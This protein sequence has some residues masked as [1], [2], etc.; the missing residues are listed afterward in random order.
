MKKLLVLIA[1]ITLTIV[2]T[3]AQLYLTG[4]TWQMTSFGEPKWVI[5]TSTTYLSKNYNFDKNLEFIVKYFEILKEE[6]CSTFCV[7]EYILK[8]TYFDY[9]N[10]DGISVPTILNEMKI[11]LDNEPNY[12]C[13][14]ISQENKELFLKSY[15]KYYN[16]NL[17][18]Y[19]D[20]H[21]LKRDCG[22]CNISDAIQNKVRNK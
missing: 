16:P 17:D 19:M 7:E 15:D 12:K 13:I 18:R 9:W 1:T 2:T 22:P 10:N 8:Y 3:N 14:N 5:S 21:F 11:W 20:K 4:N 6:N